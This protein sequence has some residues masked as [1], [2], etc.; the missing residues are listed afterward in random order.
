LHGHELDVVA[1]TDV[2]V[3]H[4]KPVQAHIDALDDALCRKV[5][6]RGIITAQFGAEQAAVSRNI[7]QGDAEQHFAHATAIERRSVDEVHPGVQSD[8]NG[9]EGLGQI[10]SAEFLPERRGAE[11]DNRKVQASFTKRSSLH[12]SCLAD[13][14]APVEEEIMR[15][16]CS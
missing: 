16:P 9:A 1:Q 5:E 15:S 7:A 14:S 11:A 4:S 12:R 8:M 10:D 13:R 3:V 2:E 6:M